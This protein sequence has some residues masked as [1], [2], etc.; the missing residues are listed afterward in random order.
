MKKYIFRNIFTNC[1]LVQ[2]I[3]KK[4]ML[5]FELHNILSSKFIQIIKNNWW[6]HLGRACDELTVYNCKMN[7]INEE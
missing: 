6:C 2:N 3:F 1:I 7:K 5:T 4:K